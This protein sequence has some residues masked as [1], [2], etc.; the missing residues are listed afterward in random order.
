MS[1]KQLDNWNSV[2]LDTQMCEHC[3]SHSKLCLFQDNFLL[4]RT[5]LLCKYA[6]LCLLARGREKVKEIRKTISDHEG[7]LDV[8]GE[9]SV[10]LVR[11]KDLEEPQE[12]KTQLYTGDLM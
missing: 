12:N 2:L 7:I 8:L 11:E 4:S 3:C 1:L 10:E 9:K 6:H 5:Q